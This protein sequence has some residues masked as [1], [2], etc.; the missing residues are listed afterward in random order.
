MKRAAGFTLIE[1]MITVAV[2]AVL[3]GIGFPS[4]RTFIENAQ[5]RTAS[6]SI[7][8]GIELARMEALRRN[9]RI[10]FWLVNNLESSCARSSAGPAWVVSELDPEGLCHK[11]ASETADARLV[12]SRAGNDGS[13]NVTVAAWN[14]VSG[15]TGSNCITF[16]GF[17][18]MEST[19]ID[20]TNPIARIELTSTANSSGSKALQ[21]RTNRGGSVRTC[22]P[23]ISTTTDPR[24]CGA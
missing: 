2:L 13:S 8:A 15:G 24:Y 19:C 9:A 20:G 3:A 5:I 10:S 14:A 1:L 12:Q 4:F 16:N 22:D 7:Q 18:R 6:N 17:G 21:I 11:P 23:H